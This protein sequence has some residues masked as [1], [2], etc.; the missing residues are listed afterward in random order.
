MLKKKT[1]DQIKLDPK[2]FAE[3]VKIKEL[4]KILEILAKSYYETDIETSIIDDETYDIL[5]DILEKR[6][7]ENEFLNKVGVK[8]TKGTKKIVKLP[9]PMSSLKKITIE[10]NKLEK[11]LEKY[12]GPYILSDKLDG[13]SVQLYKNDKNEY[14]MYSRGDR[15]EGQDISHLIPA[16]FNKDILNKIP[17]NTSVRGEMIISKEN[18]KKITDK[19]NARNT[20][21]G[22]INSKTVDMKIVRLTSIVMYSVLNPRMTHDKQMLFLEKIN[23][24]TVVW[25]KINANSLTEQILQDY[26]IE[27]KNSSI[28]E[29]DGIVC[30]NSPALKLYDI[31]VDFPEHA[32]AYKM[33][34]K[35]QMAI[36]EVINV[37]WE[38]SK[39]G[40]LKPTIEIKPV[41][42]VGVT[43]KFVTGHNANYIY[44][45]DIGP[46]AIIQIER[47]GDVIPHIVKIITRAKEPQFPDIPYEWNETEIDIILSDKNALNNK[48]VISK[49]ITFFFKTIGVK[50][51]SNSTVDKFINAGYNTIEKILKADKNKLME[52][53]NLGEKSINKIYSEIEN[54]FSTVEL[55]TFMAASHTFGRGMGER[56]ILEVIKVYPNI[57]HNDW[58]KKEMKDKILQ[59]QGFQ[60]KSASLF[61]SNFNTFI[62]FYNSISKIIDLTRFEKNDSD[63]DNNSD[64]DSVSDNN[65]FK[66][67]IIVMTG[68][69]DKDL[70]KF[71][72]SNGGKITNSISKNTSLL[73]YSDDSNTSSKL[74]K[75]K[76]LNIEMISKIKFIKKYNYK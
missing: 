59:V 27:R 56:K 48:T 23:F 74:E 40:F 69:R 43:I 50:Y 30:V 21:S 22:I 18:F 28:Y 49:I 55:H 33:K 3:N 54:A 73:I 4:V 15:E 37:I 10:N 71:I 36:T 60:D 29:L 62:K 68:F 66:G 20:V 19:K 45:N 1:I 61:A 24:N 70:E 52:I 76:K 64:S 7:P 51:L 57:L 34:I 14:Y 9:Y 67:L 2:T 17:D 72:I 12:E 32:F 39:D 41:E 42:L 53:D 58:S 6:D 47:S 65:I 13:C 16:F 26:L 35:D 11:W 8:L 5:Y 44:E 63:S 75:A 46:G 31:S 25:K 38:P